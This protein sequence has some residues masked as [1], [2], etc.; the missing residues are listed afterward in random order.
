VGASP[1]RRG[2]RVDRPRRA[3]RTGQRSHRRSTSP[4]GS[5][6][7]SSTSPA[8]VRARSSSP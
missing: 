5:R 1:R 3:G 4:A 6:G 7:L 2:R 8:C